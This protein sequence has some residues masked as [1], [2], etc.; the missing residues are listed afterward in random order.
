MAQ[1]AGVAL[2]YYNAARQEIVARIQ[3]RDRALFLYITAA[4]AYLGFLIKAF[5]VS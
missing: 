4:G 5:C 3:L 2:A 1:D